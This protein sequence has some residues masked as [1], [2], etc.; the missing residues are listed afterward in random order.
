MTDS[1]KTRTEES[2]KETRARAEAGDA[3]AQFSVGLNYR[4][5]RGGD[6]DEKA[7]QWFRR[8]AER[9]HA[10]AQ[11]YLGICLNTGSGVTQD[12]TESLLWLRKAAAQGNDIAR[13]TL[14][15]ASSVGVSA[16]RKV[17]AEEGLTQTQ[18]R[19][20]LERSGLHIIEDEVS[21]RGS[22]AHRASMSA[23]D[24]IKAFEKMLAETQENFEGIRKRGRKY[25]YWNWLGRRDYGWSANLVRLHARSELRFRNEVAAHLHECLISEVRFEDV[26]SDEAVADILSNYETLD[27]GLQKFLKR[28][29]R[30]Y[31]Y[32]LARSFSKYYKW[33][34]SRLDEVEPRLRDVA[35]KLQDSNTRLFDELYA[36]RTKYDKAFRNRDQLPWKYRSKVDEEFSKWLPERNLRRFL[37][38][39]EEGPYRGV[40]QVH[41][42]S[43]DELEFT[44]AAAHEVLEMNKHFDIETSAQT[45]E[46]ADRLVVELMRNE[47]LFFE[48]NGCSTAVDII[49][50][51]ANERFGLS[52]SR[53]A[54][55]GHDNFLAFSFFQIATLQ[56]ALVAL[57][58][59][60][61]RTRMRVKPKRWYKFW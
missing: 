30:T 11:L 19:Q 20:S 14:R 57:N 55:R 52:L 25:V 18:V 16:V 21:E 38:L 61:A 32:E 47:R 23:G 33:F 40:I 56:L 58:N 7:V 48:P 44:Q 42:D 5:N 36:A 34:E 10:E 60:S 26:D 24:L 29:L 50:N 28:W 35:R 6:S 53:H 41:V 8:A 27:D 4:D 3:D 59:S 37:V 49:L 12:A 1:K 45:E 31:E 2:F 15:E 17:A 39:N 9:G 22:D 54:L 43:T 51:L 46:F 13:K